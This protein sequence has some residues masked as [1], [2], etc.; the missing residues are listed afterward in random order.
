MEKLAMEKGKAGGCKVWFPFWGVGGNGLR[1]VQSQNVSMTT[2]IFHQKL[3]GF[4]ERACI[5]WQK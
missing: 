4:S 1:Q 5:C 3:I 2:L